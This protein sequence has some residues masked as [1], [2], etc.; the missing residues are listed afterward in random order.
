M[1]AASSRAVTLMCIAASLHCTRDATACR[2]GVDA[3][4]LRLCNAVAPAPIVTGEPEAQTM[5]VYLVIE[6]TGAIADSIVSATSSVSKIATL[7]STMM[8]DGHSMAMAPTSLVIPAHAVTDLAPGHTHIMLEQLSRPLS[9]GDTLTVT[10]QFAKSG[11]VNVP[12]RVV[13]YES[14]ERERLRGRNE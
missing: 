13:T 11:K 6:N 12:V 8:H 10:L 3:G 5:S 1:K 4:A 2:S 14:L 9:E 7:H